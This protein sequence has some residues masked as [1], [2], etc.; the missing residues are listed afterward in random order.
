M[1]CEK[2][3]WDHHSPFGLDACHVC[4]IPC[5]YSIHLQTKQKDRGARVLLKQRT[6]LSLISFVEQ[7]CCVH[8]CVLFLNVTVSIFTYLLSRSASGKVCSL[9][10]WGCPFWVFVVSLVMPSNDLCTPL[11][12]QGPLCPTIVS[13]D[14]AS[15]HHRK[16]KSTLSSWFLQYM[17]LQHRHSRD[18]HS[19]ING[20]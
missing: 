10:F 2:L 4:E 17:Q 3:L 12:E 14:G 8:F 11:G 18:L 1:D 9:F 7:R 13:M 5:V 20:P 19:S 6:C 15:R 16:T